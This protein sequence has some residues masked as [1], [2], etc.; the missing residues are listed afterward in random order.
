M[1][2]VRSLAAISLALVAIAVAAV[3]A[4][5]Y[6][7]PEIVQA[8]SQ[9]P[10]GRQSPCAGTIS[11]T[12]SAGTIRICDPLTVTVN[13][14]PE[15][16]VCP[17]GITVVFVQMKQTL[18]APW[19]VQESLSVLDLLQVWSKM[20]GAYKIQVGVVHYFTQANAALDLT[21]ELNKARSALSTP[22][23]GA[24]P[25]N[26]DYSG[27][28][29]RALEM[30]AEARKALPDASL[31]PCEMLIFFASTK[32]IYEAN[33]QDILRAARMIQ[34]DGVELFAGC[35][36][37]L[38]GYCEVTKEMVANRANYTEF[39]DHG[40]LSRMVD[41]KLDELVGGGPSLRDLYLSQVL[42][43]GLSYVAGSA[44]EPPLQ[45]TV[46]ADHK[47]TLNWAWRRVQSTRPLTITYRAKPLAESTGNI[48]GTARL[49]DTEGRQRVLPMASRPIT[50]SGLCLPPSETPVPVPTATDTA[51]PTPTRQPPTTTPTS[52]AP[53]ASAT[54]TPTAS[55]TATRT[56]G[57]LYLPVL[58]REQ[59]AP[60]ARRVDVVLAIDASTSMDEPTAAGRTKLA[61]AIDAA[62]IFL[63]QLR[64]E[65]GDQ[66]A[67][68]AF[69]ASATLLHPLTGDSAALEQA[70]GAVQ[71]AQQTCLV[72]AVDAGW[73]ELG[74]A[75]H[76][77][78]HA[79]VL[80]L[81]T[82]GRSN[83]R[84]ASEA[85]ARA[86]AA[87][88]AGLTVFTIG[89]GSDVEAG[90]LAA[91]A[92]RPEWYFPAP[93]GE[94]LAEIYRQIAVALPCPAGAFWGGR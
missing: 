1:R 22:H 55:A 63:D 12:L 26:G 45:H 28:A 8:Q 52:V 89:L 19:M 33:R 18:Q 7:R 53:V 61:A 90:A 2:A 57:A 75:R 71:T 14:A 54:S 72:C 80:V 39:N 32:D 6:V 38:D 37:G 4:E 94:A 51:T 44:S 49:V 85:I 43:P 29:R 3:V 15:C 17:G 76:A 67:I 36:E 42:P 88:A 21:D 84:P 92:S 9:P 87:K 66:A 82:D 68:V 50:V 93:D 48:E 74:S 11:G 5:R 24:F 86:G 81:L 27:A 16:P 25:T 73:A 79:A 30:L 23:R 31:E 69:N 91:M 64:F 77:P 46:G 65:R 13:V 41:R 58:L 47:T 59:C 10:V 40:R 62:R 78:D 70:L 20:P 35:P 83:P 56:P 34:S 60:D